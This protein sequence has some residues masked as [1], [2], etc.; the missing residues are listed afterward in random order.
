[1]T[2]IFPKT[3]GPALVQGEL[4]TASDFRILGELPEKEKFRGRAI[5]KKITANHNKL[6]KSAIPFRPEDHV[7][8]RYLAYEIADG[9]P[10][11]DHFN[12]WKPDPKLF[13]AFDATIAVNRD[14]SR[15]GIPYAWIKSSTREID[16]LLAAAQKAKAPDQIRARHD[17]TILKIWINDLMHLAIITAQLTGINSYIE[18]KPHEAKYIGPHQTFFI[19]FGFKTGHH[20]IAEY[21]ERGRWE[22]ILKLVD[23]HI[24]WTTF[25]NP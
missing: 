1:M 4:A 3:G 17:G 20:I 7:R 16:N 5:E 12:A 14:K 11:F 18:D 21:T 2:I 9:D 19:E 8:A 15:H 25:I 6:R 22:E 23:K 13:Y 24:D 10:S